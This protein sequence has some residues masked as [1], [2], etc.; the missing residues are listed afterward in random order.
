MWELMLLHRQGFYL[1]RENQIFFYYD[2]RMRFNKVIV[3]KANIPDNAKS[4]CYNTEFV[5]ITNVVV[6]YSCNRSD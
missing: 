3:V 1:H 6:N 4:I 5:S 2:F